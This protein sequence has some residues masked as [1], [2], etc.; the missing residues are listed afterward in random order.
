MTRSDATGEATD[1]ITGDTTR[2]D[3][4]DSG[5]ALP[6]ARHADY[7]PA[8]P[9]YPD[10]PHPSL[11]PL[12]RR[13]IAAFPQS[14]ERVESGAAAESADALR[15]AV[16][17]VTARYAY[18]NHASVG[19][20]PA[21]VA[22][23]AS[24][25]LAALGEAGSLAM[26]GRSPDVEA[27]TRFARLIN[28]APETIAFTGN[29]SEAFML[30]AQGLD[31]RSGDNVVTLESE[32]PANVYPWLN[33]RERGVETRFVPAPDGRVRLEDIAARMD[34][35]TRL[36]SVSFVGFS[37]GFRLDVAAVARLAHA[38][39]ALCAVDGIQGLG[40]LR[41]DATAAGVD[42]IAS[43]SAKWLLAP[44]H[45]GMLYARPEA[46]E[47]LRVTRRG[48]RSVAQPYDFFT[49]DQPMRADAARME[50]GSNNWLSLVALDAALA[51]LEQA[52]AEEIEARTLALASAVRRGLIERGYRVTSPG[53]PE[54]CSGIV[55]FRLP[56]RAHAMTEQVV[57]RLAGEA[58][59]V[60]SA[61]NG[62]LRVSPYFYNTMEEVQS[63]LTAL[64]EALAA[65]SK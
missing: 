61:R 27:R 59:V 12:L 25:A 14:Q 15:Q 55:A 47:R 18:L 7:P 3:L 35:R 10:E 42:F 1:R 31:W 48:W 62:Q 34:K 20:A 22:H 64:D 56:G 6:D 37:T 8:N 23:A 13:I 2:A 63:L 58:R 46:L 53:E 28:V 17:P 44:A 40:A 57:A 36:V 26:D 50:G 16:F 51:L 52:G 32:F 30:V 33:L 41:L 5:G 4:T 54:E 9:E 21:P 65:E 38:A 45:L 49:Y 39:G 19:P 60:V 11:V 29:V 43:G 24:Q